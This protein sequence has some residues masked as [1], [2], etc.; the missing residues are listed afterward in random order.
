MC[1]VAINMSSLE[2]CLVRSSAH[3][4]G[5]FFGIEFKLMFVYFGDKFLVNYIIH[6]ANVITATLWK[7]D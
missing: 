1:F 2:K 3:F 5:C 4:G 7:R 6:E